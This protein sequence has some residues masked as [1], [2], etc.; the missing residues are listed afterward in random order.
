MPRA[1]ASE[2]GSMQVTEQVDAMRAMGTDP[3][4]KLVAP[5]VLA[6]MCVL[7][8]AHGHGRFRRFN[9]WFHCF[10]LHP[11]H[12]RRGILD[13]RSERAGILDLMQGM[14]KPVIFAFLLAT[15]G[16]YKGLTVRGGTRESVA[17]RLRP[18]SSLPSRS[19]FPTSSSLSSRSSSPASLVISSPSCE[20]NSGFWILGQPSICNSPKSGVVL[21]VPT[22]DH[23]PCHPEGVR[24][25]EPNSPL[26]NPAKTARGRP[27]DLLLPFGRNV[28]F[29]S[30]PAFLHL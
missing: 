29:Q 25:P 20:L 2:L 18:W 8:P 7:P 24:E 22:S 16:C 10:L 17:P 30:P 23:S 3:N 5:R 4:R 19:W 26:G 1:W 6:T 12:R 27:R 9:R 21:S 14:A 13:A 11:A 28:K 15:I